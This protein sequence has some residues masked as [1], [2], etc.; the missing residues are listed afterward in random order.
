[1]GSDSFSQGETIGA[2]P[3]WDLELEVEQPEVS[4]S[5]ILVLP[6]AK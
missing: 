4:H 5:L 1:M 2:R 6:E 3:C